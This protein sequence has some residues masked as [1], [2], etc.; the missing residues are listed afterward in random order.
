MTISYLKPK[1]NGHNVLYKGRRYWVFEV[2]EDFPFYG[3]EEIDKIIVYDGVYD[4]DVC[5]CHVNEKGEFEGSVPYGQ[6]G[7][8]VSGKTVRD[9]VDDVSKTVKWCERN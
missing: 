5:W 2:S 3:S 9:L 6:H 7:L 8:P 1:L 4:K